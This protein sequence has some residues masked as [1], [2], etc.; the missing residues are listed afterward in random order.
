MTRPEG[1]DAQ[2]AIA[3]LIDNFI[4]VVHRP[5]F[6]PELA[7]ILEEAFQTVD[8]EL[9]ADLPAR[10]RVRVTGLDGPGPTGRPRLRAQDFDATQPLAES[11]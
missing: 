2:S 9:M 10:L 5:P 11:P 4:D 7:E 6:G 1:G 8:P 3:A